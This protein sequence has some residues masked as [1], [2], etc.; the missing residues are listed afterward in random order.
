MS[1]H[2]FTLESKIKF[3]VSS[4]DFEL[5][6]ANLMLRHKELIFHLLGNIT[7]FREIEL[8]IHISRIFCLK[9]CFQSFFKK[10][11]FM[12]GLNFMTLL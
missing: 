5:D 10:K 11:L 4:A 1:N 6:T 9:I 8:C 12:I 7:F 2:N 3:Q